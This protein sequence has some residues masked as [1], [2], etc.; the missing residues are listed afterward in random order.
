MRIYSTGR[1]LLSGLRAKLYLNARQHLDFS[2]PRPFG[3]QIHSE[4]AEI[5]KAIR[6]LVSDGQELEAQV[7]Q[8]QSIL[9]SLFNERQRIK[10]HEDYYRSL[11]APALRLP[12]EIL[13]QIFLHCLGNEP[14]SPH[15]DVPPLLLARICSP[16]RK[17][18]LSTPHL[19]AKV[20]VVFH[21]QVDPSHARGIHDWI[22]RSGS[23][24][25]NLCLKVTDAQRRVGVVS[26]VNDILKK[27]GR[28]CTSITLSLKGENA[29]LL[30]IP[31]GHLSSLLELQLASHEEEP[32]WQNVWDALGK[33]P[34]LRRLKLVHPESQNIPKSGP[35]APLERLTSLW[36]AC[37][38]TPS[39]V[40][41]LCR[42]PNLE[43]LDC[44]FTDREIMRTDLDDTF[45]VPLPKLRSLN[46]HRQMALF[47]YLNAPQL[48]QI[49]IRT[50]D[51]ESNEWIP[52]FLSF[53]VRSAC[54]VEKF[55]LSI[56][57]DDAPSIK[58]LQHMPD[59]VELRLLNDTNS[60]ANCND[61]ME[62]LTTPHGVGSTPKPTVFLPKLRR[63]DIRKF[64]LSP[65][66][67]LSMIESRW[68]AAEYTNEADGTHMY[69][70]ESVRVDML[71]RFDDKPISPTIFAR[72][73]RLR[74]EGLQGSLRQIY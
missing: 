29:T 40:D 64:M 3:S 22:S 58:I 7:E 10:E 61:L 9:V 32:S 25:L 16:W 70:F 47:S 65:E 42:C 51:V 46:C 44:H 52:C 4:D 18:A 50:L 6:S 56:S 35:I 24:P 45:Q 41:I 54:F 13:S 36:T 27:E 19:W 30:Q 48:K 69:R 1:S 73:D 20:A 14:K 34:Q 62:K 11:L 28:R 31:E 63:L 60:I 66:S 39:L 37:Y 68:A 33:D 21:T 49:A 5:E 57:R 2:N 67:L 53:L 8:A 59:L 71:S 43:E 72:F 23:A 12:T 26:V 15:P 17:V 55:V 38:G 74:S